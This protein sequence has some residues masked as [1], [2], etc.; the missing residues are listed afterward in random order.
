[1]VKQFFY[2]IY[3]VS[4]S[5]YINDVILYMLYVGCSLGIEY[6]CWSFGNF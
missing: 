5:V 6:V 4:V 1:M 2:E 3:R